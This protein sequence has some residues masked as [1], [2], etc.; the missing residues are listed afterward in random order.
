MTDIEELLPSK[1]LKAADFLAG[2]A[3]A[4]IK[5]YERGVEVG[6]RKE[7]K[8]VLH[9]EGYKKGLVLNRTNATL[10]AGMHGTDVDQWIGKKIVLYATTTPFGGE[11]KPC[12]RV[13]DKMP[14]FPTS[15]PTV[16]VAQPA[17]A[18]TGAMSPAMLEQFRMFQ[19]MQAAAASNGSANGHTNGHA[20]APAV[21]G[22]PSFQGAVPNDEIPY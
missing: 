6:M 22:Q 2:D 13:R 12:I 21:A 20:T 14:G 17:I 19:E 11:I 15:A 7:E 8:T 18:G 1:H 5:S 10:I 3:E 9:F 16:Q 4:T